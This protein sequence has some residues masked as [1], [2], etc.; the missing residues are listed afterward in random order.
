MTEDEIRKHRAEVVDE[1]LRLM[2]NAS[3]ASV[4][5]EAARVVLYHLGLLY[6]EDPAKVED[7]E[8]VDLIVRELDRQG[9]IF[10]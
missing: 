8:T 9:E 10:L 5:I 3:D 1:T 7:A 6:R 2:R 4:L